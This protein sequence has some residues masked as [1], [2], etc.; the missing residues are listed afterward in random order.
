MY[1]PTIDAPITT[2]EELLALPESRLRHELLQGEYVMT[3]MPRVV[4]QRVVQT[5]ARALDVFVGQ[6]SELSMFSVGADVYLGPDTLV[7]PDICVFHIDGAC[8]E[9]WKDFPVPL[10]AVE[11]LSPGT[12]RRDRGKKREIYQAAGV[13]EYWIVDIDSRMIE[14]WTPEHDRPEI[15]RDT[16]NWRLG[17]DGSYLTIEIGGLFE[18]LHSG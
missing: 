15:L 4:H 10:L 17:P 13:S 14:R 3:S 5:L 18:K 2:I 7:Q 6:H 9:N 16:L 1:M 12:A 8:P 11:V